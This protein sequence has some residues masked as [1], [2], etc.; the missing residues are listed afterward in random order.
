MYTLV[1]CLFIACLFPYLSKIPVAIAMKN[2]PGGYN[3]RTPRDQQAA[4][5]GFGARAVAAH[6][7][8]F[9][10]LLIFACAALTA[11]A[12]QHDS[13]TIQHLAI[14]Y[15]VSR[16]VYHVLYLIDRDVLRT[17]IWAVGLVSSLSMIYLCLPN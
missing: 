5:T 12:T 1:L 11:I 4:L 13:E 17:L 14:L 3:N 9:E 8:S 10:S 16:V 6:Q 15:L 7:N 2:Q